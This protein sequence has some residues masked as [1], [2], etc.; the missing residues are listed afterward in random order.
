M[1]GYRSTSC[2]P[3]WFFLPKV[4]LAFTYM[5]S[6]MIMHPGTIISAQINAPGSWHDSRVARPIYS[7]LLHHTP[8]GFYL[9]ADSA[10][11]RG[12]QNIAGRIR[13]PIKAGQ[14]LHGAHE[15]IENHLQF[16]QQLLSYCQTA[17]WGSCGLQGLFRRLRV[18]LEV[19]HTQRRANL[20]EVCIRA[21]CLRSRRVGLNQIQS[22]YVPHWQAE[23]DTLEVWNHFER[24][25]FSEQRR[26]DRVARF[27]I[28]ANYDNDE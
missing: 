16:D 25:L 10:F 4:G 13:T 21:F 9:V 27:H 19:N 3:F 15:D 28:Q 26:N 14:V 7:Q 2:L 24:M 22:V 1:G 20:L 17:E 12:T 8:A 23:H 6:S 5:T 18:P 11:P